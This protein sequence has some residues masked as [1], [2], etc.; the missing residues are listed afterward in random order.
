MRHG[1]YAELCRGPR[2]AM[3]MARDSAEPAV[4]VRRNGIPPDV[5]G[6]AR[7]SK[8]CFGMPGAC[9]SRAEMRPLVQLYE[10][11]GL[12]WEM[13]PKRAKRKGMHPRCAV[14][15]ALRSAMAWGGATRMKVTTNQHWSR[16]DI[17]MD[18]G[19]GEQPA[20]TALSL[21]FGHL[22]ARECRIRLP[23]RQ[24]L[25]IA[26]TLFQIPIGTEARPAA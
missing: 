20:I 13:C 15:A 26:T 3:W 18:K 6:N 22:M 11:R 16:D 7:K 1:L 2:G 8:R 24:G 14:S 5:R 21:S 25:A 12:K 9:I 17:S 19:E 4:R 23:H 10:M